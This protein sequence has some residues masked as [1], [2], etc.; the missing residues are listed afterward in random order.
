MSGV[1]TLASLALATAVAAAAFDLASGFLEP[2]SGVA[3]VRV[4]LAPAAAL[5]AAAAIVFLL[6]A[7]L[8]ARVAGERR[9][10]AFSI[11]LH[12]AIA[13]FAAAG[14][15]ARWLAFSSTPPPVWRAALVAIAIG[16]VA[17]VL[18][19]RTPPSLDSRIDRAAG[20]SAW[21]AIALTAAWWVDRFALAPRSALGVV[22]VALAAGSGAL[23]YCQAFRDRTVPRWFAPFAAAALAV[24]AF[25]LRPPS[26]ILERPSAA[27][28]GAAPSL[29]T[30]LLIVVDTLRADRLQRTPSETPHIDALLA[31]SVVFDGARSTAPWTLP[32]MASILTGTSPDLHGFRRVGEALPNGLQTLPERFSDAGYRT[33]AIGTNSV[34]L[35][36]A[37]F[38]RGFER[39]DFGPWPRR[40]T[41]LGTPLLE[42]LGVRDGAMREA[43]ARELTDR[44]C[45]W[46][47]RAPNDASFLWLHYYDPH[48]P[49]DPPAEFRPP[50]EPQRLTQGGYFLPRE[51]RTGHLV[52]DMAKRDRVRA[53]Y[54]GEARYLDR[55]IGRLVEH[56][57][58]RGLYDGALIAFTSDHGEEF[59]EH[60]SVEHGQ[61]VYDE[62]VRVPLAV[63]LPGS[64]LE[65]H[66][67]A[68]VSNAALAATLLDLCRIESSGDAWLEPALLS[69]D[70]ASWTVRTPNA[71]TSTALLFYEDRHAIAFDRW[72]YIRW[73][74]SGREELFDLERDPREARSVAAEEPERLAEGRA[75][76]DAHLRETAQW[77][78]K[79]GLRSARASGAAAANAPDLRNLGYTK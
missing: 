14:P 32:A 20:A 19:A 68:P 21:L 76:L 4:Y 39:Y 13:S 36:G 42:R 77:R 33:A 10:P 49:Y 44:A 50:G 71:P 52:A 75:K 27:P 74:V 17:A 72:K 56:L 43:D 46:L 1:R 48:F 25:A 18:V 78:E 7:V 58:A 45:A 54:D 53:F 66:V 34:L 69:G 51:V 8:G 30:V 23:A 6:V 37:G 12:A 22:L 64:P 63:K 65:S 41:W 11:G 40:A 38:E 2:E 57:K 79:L 61:S 5:G 24:A 15:A 62:L 55:E 70:G 67:E 29:R 26:A 73:S 35:P 3:D 9:T 60:E 28:S 16:I 59:W 31:D 47:D